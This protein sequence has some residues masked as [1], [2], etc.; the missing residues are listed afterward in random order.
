MDKRWLARGCVCVAGVARASVGSL[1]WATAHDRSWAGPRT[2]VG[3]GSV[4]RTRARY[5]SW[6]G[7]LARAQVSWT[8]YRGPTKARSV[9]Q[10]RAHVGSWSMVEAWSLVLSWARTSAISWAHDS[11]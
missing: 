8:G 3:A 10:A 11:W 7:S 9:A 4:A 2:M 1:V 6:A 5:K